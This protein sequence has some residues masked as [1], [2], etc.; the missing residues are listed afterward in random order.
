MSWTED[1][2]ERLNKRMIEARR[3]GAW[4]SSAEASLVMALIQAIRRLTRATGW[5]GI[6]DGSLPTVG[7]GKRQGISKFT[8]HCATPQCWTT[9]RFSFEE[10][11]L[12][13]DV[14]FVEIPR[15]RRFVCRKCRGRRVTVMADWPSGLGPWPGRQ[16]QAWSSYDE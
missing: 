16:G 8:V 1:Q 10:L 5:S 12:G 13:D 6:P 15:V 7:E 11:G 4:L 14:V 9:R 3:Q 2:L